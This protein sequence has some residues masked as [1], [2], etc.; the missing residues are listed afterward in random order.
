MPP[1]TVHTVSI[2]EDEPGHMRT[3]ATSTVWRTT[4][5]VAAVTASMGLIVVAALR[6]VPAWVDVA[7]LVLMCVASAGVAAWVLLN[8]LPRG[9]R[10]AARTAKEGRMR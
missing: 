5:V 4:I 7:L 1:H 8:E 9:A 10:G 2:T 6:G 3:S